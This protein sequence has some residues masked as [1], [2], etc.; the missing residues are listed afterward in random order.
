MYIIIGLL[1]GIIGTIVSLIIRIELSGPNIQYIT[2]EK[3]GQ[4][5]NIL[6]T[7]HGLLMIFFFV[8]PVLI[9]GFGNYIVPIQIGAVDMAN[10]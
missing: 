10:K 6:I 7:E 2:S 9:S 4:I 5:Y 8:M 1:S 3:Y